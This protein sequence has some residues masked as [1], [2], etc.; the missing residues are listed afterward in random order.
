[1]A[2]DVKISIT[3]TG[4]DFLRVQVDEADSGDLDA[5][6]LA[7]AVRGAVA[8]SL[9]EQGLLVEP[10]QP[11]AVEP[12][13]P[14]V[15]LGDGETWEVIP[16]DQPGPTVVAVTDDELARLRDGEE[17]DSVILDAARHMP[18]RDLLPRP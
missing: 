16:E 10:D 17:S 13:Y 8:D 7:R 1:M 12:R 15:I 11:T 5:N 6:A 3:Q 14:V 18:L 2:T 4:D 9:R